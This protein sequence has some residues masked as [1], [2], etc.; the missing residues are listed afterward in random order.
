MALRPEATY[1]TIQFTVPAPSFAHLKQTRAAL[2]R[3]LKLVTALFLV[4]LLMTFTLQNYEVVQLRLL[5]WTVEM[6]RALLL[7]LVFATGI[8]LGWIIRSLK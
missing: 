2:M 4:A 3:H 1:R 7:F 5:F 6:S 8:G